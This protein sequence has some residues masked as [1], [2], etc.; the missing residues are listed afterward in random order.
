M[1]I[2]II[3][4]GNVG[5]ALGK[6]WARKGHSVLFGVR[7]KND[8]SLKLLLKEAGANAKPASVQEAAAFGEVVVFATP[9]AA[10]Q[11]A[12]RAVGDL[13]GKIVFDCTNPLKPDLSGLQIGQSTSAGEQVANWASGAKVVKV[14]N[15]TGANN[16]EHSRYPEGAPVMFYC[17]DDTSAK[18]TAA[19]LAS[20]LG[21]EPI[22]AGG[23]TS[24]RLLEP[25]AM[26]WIH[27]AYAG[28]LGR[29]FAFRIMRR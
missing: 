4:S 22:D 1:K 25:L 24:A 8:E 26:L 20:D 2:G 7:D 6:G 10:A 21:F 23:L 11:D 19:Q 13:K 14:F 29:D 16:M 9:W 3:G 18:K 17:G 15:T 5:G 12:I 28:G 27:L